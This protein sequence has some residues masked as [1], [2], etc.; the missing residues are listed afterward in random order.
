MTIRPILS[1][2]DYEGVAALLSLAEN[3]LVTAAQLIKNRQQP[4]SDGQ[5][6]HQIVAELDN[7]IVGFGTIFNTNT[8]KAGRLLVKVCTHPDQRNKGIGAKLYD[9]A[10]AFAL[11]NGAHTL[12][13]N[14]F[15]NEPH[16]L[17]FAEKRGFKI[18]RHVF[19]SKIDLDSFDIRPFEDVIEQVRAGGIHLFTLAEVGNTAENLRKL[20]EVNYSTYLDMPDTTG[21]FPDFEAFHKMVTESTWFVPESQF[22][23][24]DGDQFVGLSAI[25]HNPENNYF[26][27]MMTGVM[28]AYRGRQI[29]LALKLMTITYAKQ[30]KGKSIRTNNDSQNAPM[31]AINRKLGYVPEPGIYRLVKA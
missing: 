31:L 26:Y 16:S 4:L 28:P 1:N 12:E 8:M 30:H 25:S 6:H 24:A 14:L 5:I 23:A 9:A 10:A 29:A 21:T 7:T 22:L 3:E 15:D 11:S 19:E 13:S 2:Q 27:N 17:K 20:W 18:E